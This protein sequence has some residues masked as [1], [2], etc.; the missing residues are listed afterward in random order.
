ML[1]HHDYQLGQ[2]RAGLQPAGQG[3][4]SLSARQV[5]ACFPKLT[6]LPPTETPNQGFG[7]RGFMA[8]D[9]RLVVSQTPVGSVFLA[10]QGANPLKT[11]NASSRGCSVTS[12]P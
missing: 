10:H 11:D 9:M 8:G 12:V 1:G 4:E 7:V 3:F 6:R 2:L 5:R